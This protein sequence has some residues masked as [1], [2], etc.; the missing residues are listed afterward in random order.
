[1][2]VP[3]RHH[4]VVARVVAHAVT[5]F[6]V[7][8]SAKNETNMVHWFALKVPPVFRHHR[9][10]RAD[11]ASQHLDCDVICGKFQK[12]SDAVSLQSILHTN[13]AIDQKRESNLMLVY[14][15]FVV[16]RLHHVTKWHLEKLVIV[17]VD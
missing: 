11:F 12:R 16:R 7:V 15:L 9:C 10:N 14:K 5:H 3:P 2:R 13:S 1:M 4:R 17:Q 6:R 8:L